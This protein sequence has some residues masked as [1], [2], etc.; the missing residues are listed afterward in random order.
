MIKLIFVFWIFL[1][2]DFEVLGLLGWLF[3][4][5]RILGVLLF[6]RREVIV[7]RFWERFV[8]LDG[9]RLVIVCLSLVLLVLK[10]V[11]I[12]ELLEN[13]IMV[14]LLIV[15]FC[16]LM[17]LV[18]VVWIFGSLLFYMLEEVSMR[19][20]IVWGWGGCLVRD[21][22]ILLNIAVVIRYLVLLNIL[23]IIGLGS[24]WVKFC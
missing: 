4:N 7:L 18:V 10:L 14:K 20:M 8:F 17:N 12:C 19:R 3:V 23:K 2:I 24:F 1:V 16:C 22:Y 15:K 21:S 9:V 5:R 11:R 13:F 6:C